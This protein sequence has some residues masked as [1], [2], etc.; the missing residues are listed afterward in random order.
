MTILHEGRLPVAE[1]APLTLNIPR[2]EIA[3]LARD[4][5]FISAFLD[6]LAVAVHDENIAAGWWTDPAT[7]AQLDR[8]MGELLCLVH[9]EISEGM[10]GYRKRLADDKLPQYP[11]LNVELGDAV[12]RILDIMGSRMRMGE[13]GLGEVV[14]AKRAFNRVREDHQKEA[15]LKANGKRF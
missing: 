11:M 5:R 4:S 12:I 1:T 15:R 14:E 3:T 10:E 2:S 13:V 7:G 9:S 6:E 8:N